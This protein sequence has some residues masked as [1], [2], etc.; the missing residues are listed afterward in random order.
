MYKNK[1]VRNKNHLLRINLQKSFISEKS[2]RQRWEYAEDKIRYIEDNKDI[3]EKLSIYPLG[4]V[5]VQIG[6]YFN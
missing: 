1:K 4:K 2:P 3:F 5:G 6:D